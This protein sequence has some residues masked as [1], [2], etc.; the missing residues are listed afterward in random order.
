M[1]RYINKELEQYRDVLMNMDE[2][3]RGPRKRIE[4]QIEALEERLQGVVNA[5]GKDKGITFDET[6]IDFLFVDE[7]HHHKKIPFATNQQNTKG[8]TSDGSNIAFDMFL[9]TR[10]LNE[11]NLAIIRC[12]CLAPR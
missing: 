5:E 9:K 3:E 10:Y 12:S 11:V 1:Q 4:K 6:G 8:V 2:S 7:A